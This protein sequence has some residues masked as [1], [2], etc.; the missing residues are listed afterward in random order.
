LF[1]HREGDALLLQHQVRAEDGADAHGLG[2]LLE[3]HRAVHGVGV[4][5]G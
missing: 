5:T 3:F 2:G 4:G 1:I